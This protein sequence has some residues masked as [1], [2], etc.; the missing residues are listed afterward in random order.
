M[1]T[2]RTGWPGARRLASCVALTGCIWLAAPLAA[3]AQDQEQTTSDPSQVEE[4]TVT[5]SRIPRP[6]VDTFYPAVSVGGEE[7]DDNAFTNVADALNEIPAFG[8]AD[9]TPQGVQNSFS[10]GQNFV[11]F[12]GLGSQRTLTLVNGRRFVS[13]N[14]PSIFGESG[15]LQVDFNVIPLALVDRIEVIGVGGAPI[16]GSDAIAGTIN[17]VL[18]DDFEGLD[19]AYR[20]GPTEEGDAEFYNAS[21]VAGANFSDGRGNMTF[22]AET[23]EQDSLRMTDRPFYS[24]GEPFFNTDPDGVARILFDQRINILTFAGLADPGGFIIPSLGIGAFPDGNFY[25]FD[26]N[27]SLVQ[28]TPGQAGPSSA[29]FALGGDGEDFFDLVEQAQSPLKRDVFTARVNY[30]LLDNVNFF[31]SLLYAN[32]QSR[33]LVSQGGFQ[34]FAFGG[35]SGAL[36]FDADDPF[37]SQQARDLLA[38]NGMTTFF[39][40]RFNNDIIDSSSF[41]EQHLWRY[42]AGLEGDLEF[43]GRDFRWEAYAVRGESDGETLGEGIIDGRFLNAIDVR[44]LT[45]ADLAVVSENDILAFS[46][47]ASAGVGDIVCESVFQAAAGNLTGTSG[48]GVTDEDLPFV[49]GCV[50]LN[51]FGEGVRSEAARE[52]VTGRQLTET[53]IEQTIYN[54]NFGGELFELPAGA[55]GFNIGFETR[56]E[57]AVFQP[58]LGNEVPLTRSSAFQRTGGQYQTDE[59]F[60]ELLIPVV[61]S[62]MDIPFLEMAEING[63]VREIDNDLAGNATVWTAGGRF[64]PVGDITFRGNYTESIRAPSLVELFAPITGSFSFADDP[65]DFRHVTEGPSPSTRQANCEADLGAGYDPTTFVSNVE[66]ATARGRTGGNPNLENETAKSYSFGF[67]LEPRWVDNLVITADYID[68]ALT[69]AIVSLDL[70]TLMEACY[71]SPDFP[72]TECGSFT[73]DASGQVID[74]LTGQTNAQTFNVEFVNYT[75]SY[76]FDVARPFGW[77]MTDKDLGFLTV[78]ARVSHTMQ[79]LQSVTGAPALEEVGEFEDPEYSGTFDFIWDYGD[80]TRVFWRLFWQSAAKLDATGQQVFEDLDGNVVTETDARYISNLSIA[81]NFGHLFGG[82]DHDMIVQLSVDDLFDRKPDL[83]QQAAEHFTFVELLGRRY[84]L[85]VRASF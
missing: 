55:L 68:I 53:D 48:H 13:S 25:Q 17:V 82:G 65:C 19:V 79:R 16:Y 37:L 47:T 58:A 84:T 57:R 51:L 80:N 69:Q 39:L 61:D 45:A 44:R 5:G 34:T 9:A 1:D 10:V 30:D 24:D 11:D 6:G 22:S 75:A 32:T 54:V 35:S 38:A 67:T 64:A 49:Q 8:V 14:T 74:F 71:D 29:F 20:F 56:E 81:Y 31:S 70:Q 66:N 72:V 27:S 7:L 77:T 41:R 26:Q 73:R 59:I 23:F 46:G 28:Y 63:A 78:R 3:L 43:A 40:H 50:P 15:G 83:I 18:K 12:L 4:I 85:G 76:G 36:Q 60:G 52:W 2:N 21:L 33:E 42:V 62:E